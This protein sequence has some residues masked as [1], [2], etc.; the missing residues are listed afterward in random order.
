MASLPN[1]GS[2]WVYSHDASFS[3][4]VNLPLSRGPIPGSPVALA[5]ENIRPRDGF[6]T[7]LSNAPIGETKIIYT[8]RHGN[9]PHNDDSQIWGKPV[10][11][12]YLSGL[13]KNFNPPITDE[14]VSNVGMA[15]KYLIT[16][17]NIETAPRPRAIYTSPLRRCIQTAMHMIKQTGLHLPSPDGHF[18]PATLH[19]KDGLREWMGYG[20]NHQSD[21]KGS[22]AEIQALVE[23]LRADLG[24]PVA[25]KLDVTER[26]SFHDE[27]YTDVDLRVRGVLDDIFSSPDSGGCVMLVL[28]SRWNKSFLRVLGHPP[29][30]VDNFEMVNCA[31]L[32][33]RVARRM[34][35]GEEVARRNQDENEQWHR[36]QA[37][38]EASKSAR[39]SQAVEDVRHWQDDPGSWLRLQNL[40][41]TLGNCLRRGD[42]AAGAALGLLEE[43]LRSSQG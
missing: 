2:S 13:A 31:I 1:P 24:V 30:A 5:P 21:H 43:D 23:Q 16:A 40:R 34:M 4:P 10:A 20:H 3:D 29:R 39:L 15:A 6:E 26:E 14:G 41:R 11:W 32:P 7:A 17:M 18:P 35:G 28:H 25:Y 27:T 42:L 12:R 8:L 19:I 33:Y 37:E 22:R 9:T 38:A 36:D